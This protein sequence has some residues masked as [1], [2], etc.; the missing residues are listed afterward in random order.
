MTLSFISCKKTDGS[1]P[2]IGY[3][4]IA[5]NP[6]A[7]IVPK[8]TTFKITVYGTVFGTGE[9]EDITESSQCSV[10]NA[11]ANISTTGNLSNTYT[12]TS[13]QR[14]T[15]SCTYEDMTQTVPVTIVPAVLTSLVFTKT[16]LLIGP[17]QTDSIQVYGNFTDVN[18]YV[19]ALEMTNYITWSSTNAAV[20]S[21]LLG[22]VSA[23]SSGSASLTATF[24]AI[25][26]STNV[27]VSSSTVT[28][29]ASPRGVGLLGSYYDFSLG[30]PWNAST[31]GDPFETLFGQRIDAQVNFDWSTGTNNLG[32]L[33]YFGI[34]WTGRIYIPTTGSYTFYTQSDDGVRLW[35]DDVAGTPVINNWSLH[36]SV[37]NASAPITLTGGQFYNIKME[38]FENAGYSVAQLKWDGPSITKAL[39]PQIYLFPN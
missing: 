6:E 39:I 13:V 9:Q 23:G 26:A 34:R 33:L 1:A 3:S 11:M 21:A 12:G 28:P 8:S 7:I 29:S 31:I 36:A 25:S 4:A 16:N 2:S 17:L 22:T 24:G 18:S 19:F 37:E 35:I 30:V 14:L 5:I 15:L 38:Y 27:T 10:N 32:Q 20:S